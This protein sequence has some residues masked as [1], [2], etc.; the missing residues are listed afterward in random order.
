M[1]GDAASPHMEPY[2]YEDGESKSLYFTFSAIQSRMLRDD[3]SALELDYTCTMM[4]F[5][6][7]KP[8]PSAIAMVGLG[9][10]SIA[11]FCRHYL[12]DTRM[13]VVEINPLVI[14]QRDN[15]CIPADGPGFQVIAGDGAEFVRGNPGRFDAL[16]LDGY[17][18][19][20]LPPSLASQRFYGD[21]HRLL[22][23]E[24]IL[25]VNLQY[26]NPQYEACI[27]RIRRC[28]DNAVLVVVDD[29]RANSV[30][31]AC[32][33]NALQKQYVGVTEALRGLQPGGA[34]Q[35]ASAF[36]GIAWSLS[37]QDI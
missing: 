28:F 15:F 5:L 20:G 4:G 11:K 19:D 35:L 10:G 21:C 22:Q 9:G 2:V 26:A 18:S 31:F 12:P 30:V 16:L 33:G 17:D 37:D 1:S 13:E 8:A 14:A 29:E 24:G 34:R 27:K 3:P 6:L 32:K 36:R 25:V 23:P 7:F